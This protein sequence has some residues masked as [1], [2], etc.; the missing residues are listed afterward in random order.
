M[1]KIDIENKVR[2]ILAN[3][4][5]ISIEKIKPIFSLK[6]DLGMDSF[7]AIELVFEIEDEFGIDIPDQDMT[8]VKTV[9]DIIDYIIRRIQER[10]KENIIR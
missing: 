8:E 6:D 4:L 2:G 5:D 10:D 9:Q 1:D 7:G 3:K